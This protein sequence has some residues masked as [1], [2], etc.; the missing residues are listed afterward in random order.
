MRAL[1]WRWFKQSRSNRGEKYFPD[2]AASSPFFFP[3]RTG[4]WVN[5]GLHYCT[6]CE[7]GTAQLILN[8]GCLNKC[9]VVK[10]THVR[11]PL[12]SPQRGNKPLVILSVLFYIYWACFDF[13]KAMQPCGHLSYHHQSGYQCQNQYSVD[14][15]AYGRSVFA[16]K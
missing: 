1:E 13:D 11:L 10:I 6:C 4:L 5:K 2:C 16:I 7:R 8:L 12:F 9:P 3:A 14:V 15:N